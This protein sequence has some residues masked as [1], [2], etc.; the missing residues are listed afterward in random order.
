M[1]TYNQKKSKCAICGTVTEFMVLGS[2]NSFGSPDLDLRPP[3]MERET[4]GVWVHECPYCGYVSHDVEQL[5]EVTLDWLE[6]WEYTTCD[7]INFQSELARRFYKYYK[8]NMYEGKIEAAAFSALHAAWACDDNARD[9]ENAII[10]RKC[11]IPLFDKMI[12]A[13]HENR[14]TFMVLTADLLRRSGDFEKLINNYSSMRFEEDILRKV[15]IFELKKASV[16]D[17]ACYRVADAMNDESNK[18]EIRT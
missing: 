1:T 12:K 8:I 6:S 10:C 2:T 3:G 18:D 7:G 16:G 13:G 17:D 14:E 5:S 4:M 9:K 15:I 11:A